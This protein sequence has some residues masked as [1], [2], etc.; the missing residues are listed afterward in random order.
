MNHSE[1]FAHKLHKMTRK[2]DPAISISLVEERVTGCE[3]FLTTNPNF[4]SFFWIQSN[5]DYT[6]EKVS[7]LRTVMGYDSLDF[8]QWF[9]FIHPNHR[10]LQYRLYLAI[11]QFYLSGYLRKNALKFSFVIDLP[12]RHIDGNYMYVRQ[13]ICACTLNK[14][15]QVL[16]F[17]SW[18][19]VLGH[20]D[21]QPVTLKGFS[22]QGKRL[23]KIEEELKEKADYYLAMPFTKRQQEILKLF[24][25]MGCP[26]L[27]KVAEELKLDLSTVYTHTRNMKERANQS[28]NYY[29]RDIFQ[30]ANF[31]KSFEIFTQSENQEKL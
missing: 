20:Y 11:S 3:W 9:S 27:E 5:I 6:L 17:L 2:V 23:Y 10:I 14:R 25:Q 7:N 13:R 24:I 21:G 16:H 26:D 29:F 18:H 30:I 12:L 19:D 1:Q 8:Q 4:Q 15:N 28:Y 31:F 22:N